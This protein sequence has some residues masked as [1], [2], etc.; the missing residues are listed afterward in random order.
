MCESEP[1]A[2]CSSEA[3]SLIDLAPFRNEDLRIF[4]GR[5][6]G[7][8]ARAAARLDVLDHD[9]TVEKVVVQVPADTWD[10]SSG[11]WSG[12]FGDSVRRLR[13]NG[14]RTRYE[15]RGG[16]SQEDV[17]AGIEDAVFHAQLN[18]ERR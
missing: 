3:V 10:V 11:F 17:D 6:S 15:F 8:S 4:C 9:P 2:V 13:E 12:M 5:G 7:Q 16:I 18:T 1:A 14:F